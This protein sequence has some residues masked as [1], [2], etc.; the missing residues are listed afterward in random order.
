MQVVVNDVTIGK[1]FTNGASVYHSDCGG[2]GVGQ[3]TSSTG[4]KKPSKKT[5]SADTPRAL[6]FRPNKQEE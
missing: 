1:R 4:H 6:T 3:G 2:R 5:D